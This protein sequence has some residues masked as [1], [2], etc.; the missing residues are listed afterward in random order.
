MYAEPHELGFDPS[1]RLLPGDAEEVQY[2]ITIL[3]GTEEHVYRTISLLANTNPDIIHGRGTR[4]WKAMKIENGA[5]VGEPIALKDS[6]VDDELEREGTTYENILSSSS[7]SKT[8]ATLRKNLL[9]VLAHGEVL[10]NGVVD[11]VQATLSLGIKAEPGP[12]SSKNAEFISIME[13]Q[14]L[15]NV[16][17]RQIHYRIAYKEVCGSHLHYASSLHRIFKALGDACIGE[18]T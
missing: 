7:S 17:Y 8:Q 12:S 15:L 18:L 16:T 5:E 6:W 14:H 9:T 2:E 1:I 10:I 4:V 3:C 11:Q 13:R